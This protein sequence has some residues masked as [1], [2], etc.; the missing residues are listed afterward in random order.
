[1]EDEGERS[2]IP[3]CLLAEAEYVIDLCQRDDNPRAA[4]LIGGRPGEESFR[5]Y[6]TRFKESPYVKGVRHILPGDTPDL[7]SQKRFIEGIRLLGEL[8][9][10]FDLCMPPERLPQAAKLVAA[11]P[12]TRFVP[13]PA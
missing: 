13:D 10:R 7:W 5:A 8:G 1:M 4:G 11:C 2:A 6:I 9:M 12:D 3:G